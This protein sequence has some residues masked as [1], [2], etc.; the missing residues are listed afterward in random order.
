MRSIKIPGS[1]LV[2]TV[3][4]F[5]AVRDSATSHPSIGGGYQDK[6]EKNKMWNGN[7]KHEKEKREN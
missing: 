1:T 2:K 5:I 7:G 6:R 4:I 3:I